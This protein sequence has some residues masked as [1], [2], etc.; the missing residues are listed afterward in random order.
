MT[1]KEEMQSLN[2]ELITLNTQYLSK[3]EELS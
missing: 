2:E 1:N 3:T